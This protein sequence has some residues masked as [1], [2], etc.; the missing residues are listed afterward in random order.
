MKLLLMYYARKSML[1]IS[2]ASSK[3]CGCYSVDPI[4]QIMKIS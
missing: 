4:L 2:N 3:P 1:M